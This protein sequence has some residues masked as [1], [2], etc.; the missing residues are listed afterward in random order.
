ML[1]EVQKTAPLLFEWA[2]PI[3]KAR[4][5]C[6]EGVTDCKFYKLYVKKKKA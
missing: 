1:R 2:G 4:G 6:M 5:I 3:C